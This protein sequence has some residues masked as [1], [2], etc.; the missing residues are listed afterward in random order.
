MTRTGYDH[1]E[2]ASPVKGARPAAQPAEPS[3]AR[4]RLLDA[5]SVLVEDVRSGGGPPERRSEGHTAAYQIAFP[6]RGLL[7]WHVG[8][9]D[10]VG[11]ANQVLFVAGGEDYQLS[12][13]LPGGYA[14]LIFTPALDTL[15]EIAH[16]SEFPPPGPPPVPAPQPAGQ[17]RP[18]ESA[19]ALPALG[20]RGLRLRGRWR[21]RG[22]RRGRARS[23]RADA[24]PDP[25]GARRGRPA[26]GAGRRDAP[27]AAPGQGGPGGGV[28]HADPAAPRGPGG[29]GVAGVPDRPV[30]A[31]GGGVDAPLRGPAAPWPGRWWSCPTPTTSPRWP[32]TSASPATATSRRPSG[33]LSGAPRPSSGRPPAPAGA[34]HSRSAAPA[35]PRRRPRRGPR[36]AQSRCQAGRRSPRKW[37]PRASAVGCPARRSAVTTASRS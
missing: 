23:G 16:T 21:P 35:P 28:R 36:R 2:A 19:R 15:A 4:T 18:A 3:A 13:P 25:R 20:R 6:Y 1:G 8:H 12:E 9:D 24:G 7:V 34:P 11:D 30:P 37:A 22:P 31:P 14:E 29:G 10:V 33:A 26:S 5:P 17:P 32:S 27:P